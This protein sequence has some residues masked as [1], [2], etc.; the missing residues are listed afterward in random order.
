MNQW[1]ISD[2]HFG[3][4]NIIKYS[5]RPYKD[6]D[7]MNSLM[8][9]EWNKLVKPEDE[10]YHNGDFAFMQYEEFRKLTWRLN[11]RIYLQLGN[12]DKMIIQHRQDILKQGKIVSI[13]NY[14]ELKTAG[15]MIVLFHY[16]QRV[17]NKSHHGSIHLYGHS[18]G[19]LPPHGLSV[20]AGVDCKEITHEYRPVH[21]DEVLAYMAKREQVVVDHH[22][23]K[24]EQGSDDGSR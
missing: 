17:W 1:F 11:G 10:V 13:E 7:E 8:V 19:S 22:G 4:A 3:H 5:N 20:D 2:T 15:K 23:T 16:G 21:L 24:E 14:R 9:Q 18:H 6:V 12:H